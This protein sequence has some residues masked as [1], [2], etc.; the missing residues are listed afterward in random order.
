M[1]HVPADI[2]KVRSFITQ[3]ANNPNRRSYNIPIK[4]SC[5]LNDKTCASEASDAISAG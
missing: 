3:D 4:D 1:T 2:E 5:S